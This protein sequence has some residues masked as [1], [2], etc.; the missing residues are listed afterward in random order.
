MWLKLKYVFEGRVLD[1]GNFNYDIPGLEHWL[2]NM[3][4]SNPDTIFFFT[5]DTTDIFQES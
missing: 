3:V 2:H 5:T 4:E 1:C